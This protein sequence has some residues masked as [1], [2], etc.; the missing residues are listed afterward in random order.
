MIC[1]FRG[2]RRSG[3][4]P[5]S[6]Y[7]RSP[8]HPAS[9][10][11]VP[12][13]LG[14]RH[15]TRSNRSTNESLLFCW[16]DDFGKRLLTGPG[17]SASH[18]TVSVG[19][20]LWRGAKQHP[21]FRSLY[22]S[23]RGIGPQH[24]GRRGESSTS[25]GHNAPC[26]SREAGN[27]SYDRL[28]DLIDRK[29]ADEGITLKKRQRA[30]LRRALERQDWSQ[31]RLSPN[32][33]EHHKVVLSLTDADL[34][35]IEEELN[36]AVSTVT[37]SSIADELA[38]GFGRDLDRRW[39]AEQKRQHREYREFS[40]RLHHRWGDPLSQ[41]EQLIVICT[42]LG[43]SVNRRLREQHFRPNPY[44]V[45]V[46]DQVTRPGLPDRSGGPL[47]SICR[48]RRRCHGPLACAP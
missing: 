48:L 27:L 19:K 29:L 31:F 36:H 16:G 8:G 11:L 41:L 38:S 33:T 37:I 44:T 40:R 5:P 3:C 25:N 10:R 45:E 17:Q 13:P 14:L 28:L 9:S 12:A 35:D 39:K 6:P 32:E 15:A 34:S 22:R 42:E 30:T 23:P 1:A 20:P 24:L 26:P 47:S 2:V 21:G 7:S 43:E 46:P 4:A 18:T